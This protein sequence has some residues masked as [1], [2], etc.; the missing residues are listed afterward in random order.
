MLKVISMKNLLYLFA[1]ILVL[2]TAS[3]AHA[4]EKQAYIADYGALLA[5]YVHAGERQGINTM[6]V[7]Y[8]RWGKDQLHEKTLESLQQVNPKTLSG[9]DKMAFWI[10]AYNLLTIDLIIKT[11]EKESIKNQGSL[12]KN[13]WKSHDWQINGKH[14]TLNEI[15][16]KIL[17][18]MGDPRIHVAINCASLSCP[19]LRAE[20]YIAE[21][22]DSQLD[23]QVLRFVSNQSKGVAITSSGLK[24]SE[25]FKWFAEDFGDK[26]G[27]EEFI[28]KYL[29]AAKGGKVTDYFDYNWSLNRQ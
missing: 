16:H 7:D 22:L 19:D 11:D 12:F 5:K 29:P 4:N 25:I 8:A 1:S 24:V 13:V 23:K 21:T 6:L 14:Y 17:R 10:N 26:K 15:E 28:H 20:P 18:P 9:K 27:V 3:M 2:A